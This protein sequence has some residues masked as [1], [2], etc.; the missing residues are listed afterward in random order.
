MAA[1]KPKRNLKIGSWNANKGYLTKSKIIEI[2][3][4][5]RELNLDICAV[6][7][8]DINNTRF[9]SDSLYNINGYNFVLPKS[10]KKGRAR[11]I[12][13]YKTF[14]E[15]H[16]KIRKDL[17]S[18][19]QPD[20]W[21]EMKSK[22][23][24]GIVIGFYYREFTGLDGDKS[25]EKQKERLKK[26]TEAVAR[27]EDEDKEV[28]LMG[29]FNI[30]LH[31]DHSE[32]DNESIA[33]I[34][35]ACCL[36]NG[37]EQLNTEVTRT[38]VVDGRLE[39]S[40]LDHI[41]SSRPTKIRKI[42]VIKISSSDHDL[43]KCERMTNDG[44]A[45]EKITVRTFKNFD[46]EEY[47]R[48]LEEQNWDEFNNE[49]DINKSTNLLTRILVETLDKHAPKVSFIPQHKNKPW[50]SNETKEAMKER[51]NAHEK[52]KKT[53]EKEDTERWRKLRNRV[54]GLLAKDKRRKEE[55]HTKANDAWRLVKEIEKKSEA[56]GPPKKLRIDGAV[57]AD[58]KKIA[59]H[60]N[61]FFIEKIEKNIEEI[62][63]TEAKFCPIDHFKKHIEAPPE[64]FKFK[65]VTIKEVE[66][67]I[68]NLKPGGGAG[69]DELPNNV[70]KAAKSVI[71]GPLT[72]IINSA[73]TEGVFPKPWKESILIPLWKHKGDKLEAK[74]HRPIHILNKLSLCL[75]SV[76][77]KQL[78]DHWMKWNLISDTQHGYVANRS[79]TTA[80]TAMYDNWVRQAD[81]GKYVGIYLLDMS[82]A[83]ELVNPQILQN[84][85]E[86]LG[87]EETARKLILDYLLDRT[88][89][90]KI[91]DF[92][93][94]KAVKNIG[95]PAGSRLGP[96][97]YSI[98]TTD[99]PK[100]TESSIVSFADDSTNSTSDKSPF[101]VKETLEADA[102]LI[103]EYM[104]S[105]RL[106]I[107]ES[108]SV[109]ILASSKHKLRSEEVE[110]LSLRIGK[111]EIQQSP[112]ARLLGITINSHLDFSNHLFGEPG[113]D[114]DEGLIKKLSKRIGLAYK[115]KHLPF[116]MRK[117]IIT[118]TFLSKL[119]YGIE[120]WGA[121]SRGQIR[122][123]ELLQQRASRLIT[124]NP[125]R[126]SSKE[127]LKQCGWI[128]VADLRDLKTL[129]L[130]HKVRVNQNIKYLEKWIGRGR[131]DMDSKIT[132]YETEQGL[133]L[134]NS[135]VPR[136]I[137]LWNRLPAEARREP[138]KSF[139]KVAKTFL[140]K[141]QKD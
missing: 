46:K 20:V 97:M 52:C 1:S 61:K 114:G 64:T 14:L 109:F 70:I 116:R 135:T 30:D 90:T 89:Q 102:E 28:L 133:I 17:M 110:R 79:C 36:E 106:L 129:T 100:T 107:A 24:N 91:G 65:E 118:G 94:E 43:I 88:Q 7:E 66:E 72:K 54:V 99:L 44:Y 69:V 51:D 121:A 87:T 53:K 8:V 108:K 137:R 35:K 96:I 140:E 13:Y 74:S 139:K 34:M 40:C 103:G 83:F 37:L 120:I 21:M 58:K 141:V 45:P 23:D 9:H 105:N 16:L 104:R 25:V 132:E 42:K 138:I 136:F 60:I 27:V 10:W 75:E 84:K 113:E 22:R 131:K 134:K 67:V 55:V 128:E 112:T 127:N 117:M 39:A 122:Q 59:N 41:Y 125:R 130:L 73:I 6:S 63:K 15:T 26:F 119:A 62:E 71:K 98:Y 123:I 93:S 38:R 56:G 115:I 126:I 82:S 95:V 81:Q 2:E 5:M 19:E 49:K 29:D 86:I 18:Q 124:N 57:T 32:E 111:H 68:E 85:L 3:N 78:T 77:L 11:I 50:L 80:L 12:V 33:N 101:K 48:D 76:L 4:K 92:K 31:K 47:I